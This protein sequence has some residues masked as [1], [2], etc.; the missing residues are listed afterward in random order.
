MTTDGLLAHVEFARE[1]ARF[2]PDGPSGRRSEILLKTPTLRVILVTMRAGTALHEHTA[3]GPIT[4]QPLAGRFT[5][6]LEDGELD[7]SP[8]T[9]AALDG[10][11]RHAVQAVEDGA[12]LLTI[13]WRPDAPEMAHGDTSGKETS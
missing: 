11:V 13:A 8:G 6:L 5:L 9:L 1:I 3:P 2:P 7:L 12:F 10:G 4:V